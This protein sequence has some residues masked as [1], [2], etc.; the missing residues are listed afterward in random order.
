VNYLYFSVLKID[1]D[2]PTA[3]FP[4]GLNKATG[5]KTKSVI[6]RYD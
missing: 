2:A 1:S 3:P 6:A 4:F 5:F